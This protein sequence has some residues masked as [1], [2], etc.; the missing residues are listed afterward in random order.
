MRMII[1]FNGSDIF[2]YSI[3]LLLADFN[4][5]HFTIISYSKCHNLKI[6]GEF[7]S[8]SRELNGVDVFIYCGRVS[9]VRYYGSLIM[10][11][12]YYG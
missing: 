4:E 2:V 6:R 9:V 8:E 11:Y 12:G 7:M 5:H 10:D 1:F 3:F